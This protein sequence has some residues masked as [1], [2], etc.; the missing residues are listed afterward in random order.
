LDIGV[1]G[2]QIPNVS[3]KEEVLNIVRMS[4]YPPIGNRGFSPFTRAGNYSIGSATT[5]TEKANKNTLLG[6][7][8]EGKEAIDNLDSILEI[9]SLDIIFIGL[10]DL[11]KSLGIPGKVDDPKVLDCLSDLVNK[12]NSAGKYPGTIATSPERMVSFLEMGFKYLV[13]LVDCEMLR[14][15]YVNIQEKFQRLGNG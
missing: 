15:S 4:K 13:Y 9:E 10:F 11:S 2:L 1:H 5:L 7:N 3:S 6:I 12:I 14:S 8:V